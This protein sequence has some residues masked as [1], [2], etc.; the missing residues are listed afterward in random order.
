LRGDDADVK[1]LH[2]EADY[3]W[4]LKEIQTYFDDEPSP[5]TLEAARCNVMS[6]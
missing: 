4:A 2:T 3:D 6:A 1:Q 5:G